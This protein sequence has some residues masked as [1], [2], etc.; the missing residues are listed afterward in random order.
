MITTRLSD[1][2]RITLPAS[3]LE[4]HQWH[5]G[6]ELLVENVGDAVV[7]RPNPAAAVH[8]EDDTVRLQEL[9]ETRHWDDID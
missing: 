1:D 7:L 8:R 2:G 4:A 3:V 6:I 9:E 5:A